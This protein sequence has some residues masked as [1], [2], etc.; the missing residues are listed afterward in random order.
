MSGWPAPP[1]APEGGRPPP[2]VSVCLSVPARR[3]PQEGQGQNERPPAPDKAPVGAPGEPRREAPP[4]PRPAV[5]AAPPSFQ[6]ITRWQRRAADSGGP[7]GGPGNG[8]DP[9]A[10]S[11]TPPGEE[12][13]Q[14]PGQLQPPPPRGGTL[15][16]ERWGLDLGQPGLGDKVGRASRALWE[17]SGAGCLRPTPCEGEAFAGGC[18]LTRNG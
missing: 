9:E 4:A 1:A 15:A 5:R 10:P 16:P 12:E 11:L 14:G 8:R 18:L 7:G 3:T 2:R 6:R 17:V 13:R